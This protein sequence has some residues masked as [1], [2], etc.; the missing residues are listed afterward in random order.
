VTIQPVGSPVTDDTD[1]TGVIIT[2]SETLAIPAELVFA[3][4]DVDALEPDNVVIALHADD[5]SWIAQP[6]VVDPD[7]GTAT[8]TL[9]VDARDPSATFAAPI[10][11]HAAVRLRSTYIM[12]RTATVR[13]AETLNLKPYGL[14]S[15]DPCDDAADAAL[16]TAI[17][18][19][20]LGTGLISVHDAFRPARRYMR[21]LANTAPNY[22]RTWTVELAIGGSATVGR[23]MPSGAVGAI[24]TA[25]ATEPTPNPVAVR[26]ASVQLTPTRR[27]VTPVPALITIRPREYEL[28]FSYSGIG[29]HIGNDLMAD[30]TDSFTVVVRPGT[31]GFVTLVEGPTNMP[32]TV[33]NLRPA[34]PMT[35]VVQTSPFEFLTVASTMFTTQGDIFYAVVSGSML[36]ADTLVTFPGGG[37]PYPFPGAVQPMAWTLQ[38]DDLRFA[39]ITTPTTFTDLVGRWRLEVVPR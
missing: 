16:C 29:D 30:V 3:Y 13:P 17:V 7:A 14:F 38:Y 22:E 23:I 2:S 1:A 35:S 21:P 25:P 20:G 15:D 26:F 39:S 4:D 8:L 31:A 11:Y 5:G 24:Y 18:A 12:P 34:D 10:R 37:P 9:Q 28:R 27:P 36:V 6:R 32:S 19:A 33:A